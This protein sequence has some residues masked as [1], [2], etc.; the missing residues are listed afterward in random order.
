MYCKL[1]VVLLACV[2]AFADEKAQGG[3]PGGYQNGENVERGR[4]WYVCKDGALDPRG[5]FSDD[6][7]KLNLHETFKS[8]GF[9]LE[10]TTDDKGF[11]SFRYKGCATDGGKEV[12]AG[13]S[14][15]DGL[16]VYSC[17]SEG[18]RLRLE[19]SGCVSEGKRFKIGETVEKDSLSYECR[20][21]GKDSTCSMCPVGCV[22]DGKTF[23]VGESFVQDKFV[24]SCTK[25]EKDPTKVVKKVI[26]CSHGVDKLTD[27][28]RYV[29]GDSV[30]ECAIRQDK[31]PEHRLVGCH[32]SDSGVTIERRLHCQYTKGTPPLRYVMAC[33]SKDGDK[34]AVKTVLKCYYGDEK[35]GYEIEPGCYQ[36]LDD[37]LLACHA[38]GD[39]MKLDVFKADQLQ[40]AYKLGV[41]LCGNNPMPLKTL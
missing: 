16:Y 10:C 33:D 40:E 24:Y 8:G 3:C 19:M 35:G 18:E 32:D 15:E 9:V 13:D 22:Q 25:D 38:S 30:F 5:C 23:K 41:K 27:G 29:D 6:K 37:K 12:N 20:K 2:S 4:Y 11:L 36:I 26:G 7:K 14:V 21:G 34:T 28:D 17:V 1:A 31:T 39:T